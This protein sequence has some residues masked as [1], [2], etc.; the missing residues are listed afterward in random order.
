MRF[1]KIDIFHRRK[2]K[3][4]TL[5]KLFLSFVFTFSSTAAFT[6][7]DT[8]YK[9]ITA[10]IKAVKHVQSENN[11]SKEELEKASLALRSLS[12]YPYRKG[13]IDALFSSVEY[14]LHHGPITSQLTLEAGLESLF[15][16]LSQNEVLKPVFEMYLSILIQTRA[17]MGP[18]TA[19]IRNTLVRSEVSGSSQEFL[20]WMIDITLRQQK[21]A[22]EEILKEEVPIAQK[23][24]IAKA[25]E[26]G[27]N[28]KQ[29]YEVEKA[30]KAIEQSMHTIHERS[31]YYGSYHS[32]R[33][34]YDFYH[35]EYKKHFIELVE[36]V[37]SQKKVW[38]FK[39]F[40]ERIEQSIKELGKMKQIMEREELLESLGKPLFF[41]PEFWKHREFPKLL[42]LYLEYAPAYL[43]DDILNEREVK[44]RLLKL[45]ELNEWLLRNLS[46]R[47]LTYL[48][49]SHFLTQPEVQSSQ[50]F[51]K[52]IEYLIQERE[53]WSY[54][55]YF[56]R[57]NGFNNESS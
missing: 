15:K 48:L 57:G 51:S 16:V 40:S 11:R 10:L 46:D 56:W 29:T 9:K 52:L 37:F 38:G 32:K 17:N 5:A 28:K 33:Y 22:L 20:Y 1:F 47:S 19:I 36:H 41:Q 53:F 26:E 45:P 18:L 21:S 6:E 55:D 42:L 49:I 30:M 43:V 7:G 44:N 34:Y 3:S 24:A 27:L 4:Y 50:G 54:S 13:V 12:R 8:S 39:G 31:Y 25:H 2:M 14:E 23:K 35:Y